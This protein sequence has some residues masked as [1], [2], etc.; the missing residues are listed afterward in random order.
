LDEVGADDPP[1]QQASQPIH[2]HKR[3]TPIATLTLGRDNK[4]DSIGMT[5]DTNFDDPLVSLA[6]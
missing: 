1:P 6:M 2:P 4:R 3:P 5:S